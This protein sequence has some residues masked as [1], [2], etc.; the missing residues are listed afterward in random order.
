MLPRCTAPQTL[1]T[2]YIVTYKSLELHAHS[3]SS[4]TLYVLIISKTVRNRKV[5]LTKPCISVLTT[6]V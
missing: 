5:Y 3:K 2:A 1:N 6:Y 4:E